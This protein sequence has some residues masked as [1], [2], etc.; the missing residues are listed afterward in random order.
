MVGGELGRLGEVVGHEA[1][2]LVLIRE[3]AGSSTGIGAAAAKAFG[4]NGARVVVHYNKSKSEAEKVAA[5]IERSGGKAFV[6]AGDVS[7]ST[8]CK[9]L[10]NKTVAHFASSALM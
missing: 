3:D 4:A 5:E 10:V 7:G 9:D 1:P 2:G 8:V 6:V